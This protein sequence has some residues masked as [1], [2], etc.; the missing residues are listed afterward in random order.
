VVSDFCRFHSSPSNCFHAFVQHT[1]RRGLVHR[2]KRLTQLLELSRGYAVLARFILLF[3]T[4]ALCYAGYYQNLPAQTQCLP[5]PTA[6]FSINQGKVSL[7]L[8]PVWSTPS[9]VVRLVG[10]TGCA[11]CL[12]G[13]Y[14]NG[15]GQSLCY[16]CSQ[17]FFQPASG[18]TLCFEVLFSFT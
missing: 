14:G 13:T 6:T 7:A 1:V 10:V 2:W 12:P 11:S 5:C 4:H 16:S 8:D 17:G 15:T 3:P 18:Q 9:F